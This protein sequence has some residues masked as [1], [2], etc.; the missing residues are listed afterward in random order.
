MTIDQDIACSYMLGLSGVDDDMPSETEGV[1]QYMLHRA[2]E[3]SDMLEAGM[4]KEAEVWAND[5]E[6]Q[7][8]TAIRLRLANQMREAELASVREM[9]E[10]LI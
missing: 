10:C 7:E 9:L 8:Y 2:Q 6:V 5:K 4:M 3:R 1:D